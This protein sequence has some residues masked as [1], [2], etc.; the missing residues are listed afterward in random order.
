MDKKSRKQ[1]AEEAIGVGALAQLSRNRK[2]NGVG[3]VFVFVGIITLIGEIIKFIF[4]WCIVKP[5]ILTAKFL[6]LFLKYGFA[7]SLTLF[8]FS[9]KGV[10]KLIDIYKNKKKQI[11]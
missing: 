1:L 5:C 8:Q 10:L 6:W 4:N 11:V 7:L 9:Y 2:I 3:E